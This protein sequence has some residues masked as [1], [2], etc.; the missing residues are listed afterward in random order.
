MQMADD[1]SSMPDQLEQVF[2][3][4]PVTAWNWKPDSWEGVPGEEFSALEHLCHV[5]D[6][7]VD[8]YLVRIRRTLVEDRPVLVSLDGRALAIER[9]YEAEDPKEVLASFKKARAETV[10]LLGTIGEPELARRAE[11]AEYGDVSLAGLLALLRSHDLQ[12]LACMQWL[13]AKLS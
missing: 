1:L 4:V 13:I 2:G 6:I 8:G 12:H 9:K 5:R 7:E 11:F 3:K 10:A